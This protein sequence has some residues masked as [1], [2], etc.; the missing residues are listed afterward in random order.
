MIYAGD[1]RE[2]V[3]AAEPADIEWWIYPWRI[4]IPGFPGDK[5]PEGTEFPEW[6]SQEFMKSNPNVNVKWVL[7]SNKEKH[8]KTA[9]AIAAGTTPNGQLS[10]DATMTYAKAGLLVPID[11][12]MTG[13]DK[14]DFVGTALDYFPYTGKTWAFPWAFGNNGMG[15]T[16]LLYP[17]MFEEASFDWKKI[18]EKG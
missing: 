5:A 11:E 3:A 10:L 4:R 15:V 6:V 13:D 8:Q 12:Y 18:V 7:V 1:G 14:K 16:N 2:E 17:P 9:T